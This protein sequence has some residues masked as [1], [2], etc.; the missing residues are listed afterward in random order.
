MLLSVISLTVCPG[1]NPDNTV[2]V[3][4]S[5]WLLVFWKKNV[6]TLKLF[7]DNLCEFRHEIKEK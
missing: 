4:P 5:T 2:A 6:K 7:K 3:F 1:K